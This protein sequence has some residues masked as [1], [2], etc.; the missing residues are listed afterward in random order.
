MA[1]FRQRYLAYRSQAAGTKESGEMA[2]HGHCVDLSPFQ[3]VTQYNFATLKPQQI[4]RME[5][6]C[7]NGRLRNTVKREASLRSGARWRGDS[8]GCWVPGQLPDTP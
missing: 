7:Q 5:C 1:Y 8:L 4:Q 2:G 3:R 6:R